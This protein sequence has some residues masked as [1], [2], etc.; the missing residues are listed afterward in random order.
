MGGRGSYLVLVGA[1]VCAAVLKVLVGWD[2]E[3]VGEEQQEVVLM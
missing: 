1:G 2:A 3:L